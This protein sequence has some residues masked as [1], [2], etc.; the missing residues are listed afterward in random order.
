MQKSKKALL[1]KCKGG[2][3]MKKMKMMKQILN[4]MGNLKS[5][6]SNKTMIIFY[7]HKVKDLRSI[8]PLGNK[9]TIVLR[10]ISHQQ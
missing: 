9:G 3:V 8:D 7:K 5:R 4:L 2:V 6:L 10:R 1:I